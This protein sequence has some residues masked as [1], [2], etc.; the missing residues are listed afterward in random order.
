MIPKTYY[1]SNIGK[2]RLAMMPRPRGN[3]WLEEEIEGLKSLSFDLVVSFL[4]QEEELEL[5]LQKECFFCEQI[6]IKFVSFPI[7]DRGLPEEKPFLSLITDL[8]NQI[9]EG[10]NTILHC[11]GGIGRAGITAASLLIKS[12]LNSEDAFCIVSDSRNVPV[13]DTEEQEKWIMSIENLL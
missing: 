6:G 13:P 8:Y 2:G 12:G 3:D 1:I 9:Y 10:R 5:E 4:T 7:E 11:R